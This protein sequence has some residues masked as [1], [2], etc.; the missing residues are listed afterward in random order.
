MHMRGRLTRQPIGGPFDKPSGPAGNRLDTGLGAG[1]DG[2]R[3][4]TFSNAS[5]TPVKI[6]APTASSGGGSTA[7][8]QPTR[9]VHC[10]GGKLMGDSSS[11]GVVSPRQRDHD[12]RT[13]GRPMPYAP[14]REIEQWQQEAP[15]RATRP[16]TIR[17]TNR[18]LNQVAPGSQV[19]NQ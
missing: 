16:M 19:R 10:A 1:A 7:I 3:S 6:Y 4:G 11:Y 8:S 14:G 2:V 12:S 5:R 18:A 17:Q 15:N 13:L 9:A